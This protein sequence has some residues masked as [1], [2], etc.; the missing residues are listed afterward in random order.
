MTAPQKWSMSLTGQ[1]AGG[2]PVTVRADLP[3]W[4]Y[5]AALAGLPY[6]AW[7]RL[8]ALLAGRAPSA[9]WA[10]VGRGGAGPA[11]A[12]SAAAVSVPELVDAHRRAGVVVSLHGGEGYPAALAGDH[13][14]APVLFALGDPAAA[15]GPRVAVVGTRRCTGYG[16]DVAA[17][18][19]R[20]LARAGV[21]VV[22]GLALGVDGAA[23]RGALGAGG[24]PPVAVVGSGL[25]VVYPRRH[26]DLWH[27]VAAAGL[28]LSEAPLGGRPEPWRFPARNRLLA[29]LAHVVVVVETH[30]SGGSMHTVRAAE[31][32][33]VPVLA[34]PGPVRSPASAGANRLIAEGCAPACD[35]T[36]V[37]V[38]LSL[39]TAGSP[40]A[41]RPS[42]GAPDHRP[43]PSAGELPVL[44]A[45]GWEAAT[46]ETLLQR[47]GLGPAA[48]TL[49]LARLEEAGRARRTGG[50]WERVGGPGGPR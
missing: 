17:E 31:A 4:A 12:R 18:L 50:W 44:D 29:A 26:R 30:A 35:S 10:H 42:A 33:G 1:P 14:P 7:D 21:A 15:A 9:A 5:A 41:S 28:V 32:R 25:D 47:T 39:Q 38:A 11:L 23:H 6:M 43:P 24:A 19:G 13:E 20:D 40:P 16:R 48:V 45:L 46:V 49:A 22:S 3:E 36:D 8:A 34:V 27:Q 37:L 2:R